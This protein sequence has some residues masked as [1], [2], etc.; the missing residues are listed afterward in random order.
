MQPPLPIL[1][2]L[3]WVRRHLRSLI[4]L[5]CI[6]SRLSQFSRV[7]SFHNSSSKNLPGSTSAETFYNPSKIRRK[8]PM[9]FQN[10]PLQI[11]KCFAND[12]SKDLPRGGVLLCKRGMA[13]TNPL[14]A[15]ADDHTLLLEPSR[16][17]GK[18][19][20]QH[21]IVSSFPEKHTASPTSAFFACF[22]ASGNFYHWLY[23][24]LPLLLLPPWK[25]YLE[26]ADSLILPEMQ[27]SF[28]KET[29]AALDLQ[30]PTFPS[31]PGITKFDLLTVPILPQT[32]GQ[33]HPAVFEEIREFFRP[34]AKPASHR[35]IYIS[36]KQSVRS[37]ANETDVRSCLDSR[38]FF[39]AC[40]E[41]MSFLDQIS[42]FSNAEI[43]VAPHG[44]GLSHIAFL[45]PGAKVLELFSQDFINTCYWR[46]SCLGNFDY[47]FLIGTPAHDYTRPEMDNYFISLEGLASCLNEMGIL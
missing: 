11:Q 33:V 45:P 47:W 34:L 24:V 2:M 46:L 4:G 25:K 17:I 20:Y 21:P 23:D 37:V 31:Y 9:N 14:A 36:R 44:A 26:G 38:G 41:E 30:I 43:I 16:Q 3:R 1:R 32:T 6:K 12:F 5:F 8:P 29:I 40:L 28:Q 18:T 13:S 7:Y 22:D 10:H 39:S 42:L 15:L 19:I 35:R 27:F